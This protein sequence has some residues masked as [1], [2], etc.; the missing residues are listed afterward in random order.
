MD[1]RAPLQRGCA[2]WEGVLKV[3]EGWQPE[4][5]NP[6]TVSKKAYWHGMAQQSGWA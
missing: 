3:V 2:V 5:H 4:F 6:W 1:W